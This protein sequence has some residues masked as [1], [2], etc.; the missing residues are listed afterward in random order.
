MSESLV[1][2]KALNRSNRSPKNRRHKHCTLDILRK[3]MGQ[4]GR[5]RECKSEREGEKDTETQRLKEIERR[6]YQS[7][8][9]TELIH[10]LE[11]LQ[12]S[13]LNQKRGRTK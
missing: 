8:I 2:T 5:E 1:D 13:R 9:D 4:R 3:I 11:G 12:E 10:I 7:I 6:R